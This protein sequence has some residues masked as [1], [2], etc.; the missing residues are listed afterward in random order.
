M[1]FAIVVIST[2]SLALLTACGTSASSGGSSIVPPVQAQSTYSNA[3]ISGTYSLNL[4][5]T[6]NSGQ[7]SGYTADI[8]SFTADGAGN[9]TAGTLMEHYAGTEV[10]S[11]SFTG[12]YTLQSNASGTATLTEKATLVNGAGPCRANLSIPF[13]IAAGQQGASL[14]L[15]ESDGIGLLSGIAV[16]Q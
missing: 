8:G 1:K 2:I 9:I 12:T 5:S 11:L 6:Y 4:S 15:S 10:C 14:L 13:T 3:S 16:K 7:G